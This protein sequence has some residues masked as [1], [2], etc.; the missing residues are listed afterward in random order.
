V[1]F[2]ENK[3][4]IYTGASIYVHAASNEAFGLS[5]AEAMHYALPIVAFGVDAVTEIV[6]DS[7]NGFWCQ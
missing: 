3:N 5:I 2:E 7:I 4:K 6:D 1:G